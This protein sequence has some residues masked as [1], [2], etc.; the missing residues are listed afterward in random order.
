[1]SFWKVKFK[2]KSFK[3]DWYLKQFKV[4]DKIKV[5]IFRTFQFE[6]FGK[7]TAKT[8]WCETL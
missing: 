8:L 2:K 4:A 7:D 3:N 6:I 5:Y 1:M